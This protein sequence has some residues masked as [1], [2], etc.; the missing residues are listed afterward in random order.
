MNQF[1]IA[2]KELGQQLTKLQN[3]GSFNLSVTLKNELKELLESNSL[4]ELTNLSC[5]TCIRK[6]MYDLIRFQNQKD[7]TPVLQ[8]SF[9]KKPNEMSYKELRSACKAKGIKTGK[10]PTKIN[11]INLLK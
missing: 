5:G 7:S 11:L 8:M 3:I 1:K 9:E 10:N 2:S 6:S 4:P